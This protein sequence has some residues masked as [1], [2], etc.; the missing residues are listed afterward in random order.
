MERKGG[1]EGIESMS[2]LFTVEHLDQN[3]NGL[4]WGS[5]HMLSWQIS[6][7]S[8]SEFY[9]GR[10]FFGKLLPYGFFFQIYKL[11]QTQSSTHSFLDLRSDNLR[12]KGSFIIFPF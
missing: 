6:L 5:G 1:R 8:S 3:Y 10:F 12:G 2:G 11:G 7:H 9:T 4:L